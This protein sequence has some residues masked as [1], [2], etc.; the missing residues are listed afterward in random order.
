MIIVNCFSCGEKLIA[1]TGGYYCPKC[2][3]HYDC[4]GNVISGIINVYYTFGNY[5]GFTKTGQELK[6]EVAPL[7]FEQENSTI[8]VFA[9][10]KSLTILPCVLKEEK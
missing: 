10:D 8:S 9:K 1:Y 2:G 4:Y 3:K 5:S 6:V 7:Q